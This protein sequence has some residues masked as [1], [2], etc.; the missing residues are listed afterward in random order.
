MHICLWEYRMNIFKKCFNKLKY[1]MKFLG[2]LLL[3]VLPAMKAVDERCSH[4]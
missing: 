1:V 2:A 4:T 3:Y